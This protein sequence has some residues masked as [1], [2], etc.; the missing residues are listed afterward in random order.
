MSQEPVTS[1]DYGTP[2]P[3]RCHGKHLGT[4]EPHVCP[5]DEDVNDNPNSMCHC[6]RECEQECCDDI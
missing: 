6:C 4:P 5:Y 1:G 2:C 3:G